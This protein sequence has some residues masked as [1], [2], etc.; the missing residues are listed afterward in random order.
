MPRKKGVP[1]ARSDQLKKRRGLSLTQKAFDGLAKLAQRWGFNS[2]SDLLEGIGR[3]E[4]FLTR[5]PQSLED[6]TLAWDI[7]ELVQRSGISQERL[8]ELQEEKGDRITPDELVGLARALK[9]KVDFLEKLTHRE[10]Q[11][12]GC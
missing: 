11:A 9:V 2:I 1:Y 6:L 7:E 3:G 4:I 12:N 10:H 5:S 8:I